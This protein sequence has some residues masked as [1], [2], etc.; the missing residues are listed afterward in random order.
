MK[1]ILAKMRHENEEG[2]TLIELMIVVVIIGILAA[3]AIPIFANQQKASKDAVLKSDMKN[4]ALA[5][6]TYH[7]SN[8]DALYPD[9]YYRM[10]GGATNPDN[11]WDGSNVAKYFKPSEGIHIHAFDFSS[12]ATTAPAQ[13]FC[14][15]AYMDGSNYDGTTTANT[16]FWRSD[17]GK[18]SPNCNV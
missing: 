17:T 18:F 10:G 4:L 13:R 7:T 8:K 3:I 12:Y 15:Q 11:V 6:E 2:F 5:Y 14:I 9:L 1:N 16:M